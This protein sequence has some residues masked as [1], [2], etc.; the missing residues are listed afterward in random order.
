[1][2]CLMHGFTRLVLRQVI[3]DTT[4]NTLVSASTLQKDIK[5]GLSSNN[6]GTKVGS[7]SVLLASLELQQDLRGF[8]RQDAAVLV[9]KKIAEKCKEKSIDKVCFDRGGFIYH[10]RVQ[11]SNL[12]LSL[13]SSASLST[14][15]HMSG[16]RL[17][18]TQHGKEA[19]SSD[20]TADSHCAAECSQRLAP[21][22][23]VI[24]DLQHCSCH[25]PACQ[26]L[27]ACFSP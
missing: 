22:I 16:C 14:S 25:R 7:S 23:I 4:H 6:G 12:R 1:M 9:G 2:P 11:A 19:W 8:A 26:R 27:T 17:W 3:D 24:Q 10:G 18:L 13:L 20:A 5:E 21:V 15:Q